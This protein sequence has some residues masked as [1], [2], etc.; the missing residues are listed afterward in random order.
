MVGWYSCM[1]MP[2]AQAISLEKFCGYQL[3]HENH[4]TFPPWTICNIA[5]VFHVWIAT[6]I[7]FKIIKIV[8][9][10]IAISDIDVAIA[11]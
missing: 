3:I 9:Y 6:S 8:K 7:L 11:S 10:R 2:I 4:V 1:G 5:M